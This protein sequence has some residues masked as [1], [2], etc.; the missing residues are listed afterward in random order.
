MTVL[1]LAALAVA[2]RLPTV[3]G[4]REFVDAGR[5]NDWDSARTSLLIL[6]ESPCR[7]VS[8]VRR[9]ARKGLSRALP[10]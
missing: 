3:Y 4:E 1:R 6:L 5:R 7:R 9:D 8:Q 2:R 10:A